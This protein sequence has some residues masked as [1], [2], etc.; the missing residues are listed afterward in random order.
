MLGS[1]PLK[2]LYRCQVNI[3]TEFKTVKQIN[4]ESFQFYNGLTL[5]VNQKYIVKKQ[6]FL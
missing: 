2:S 3:Y 1:K 5:L 4:H 6:F